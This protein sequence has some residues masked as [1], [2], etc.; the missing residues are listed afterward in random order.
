MLPELKVLL[1]IQALDQEII[2]LNQQLAKYPQIW[3]EVKTRLAQKRD[4]LDRA[5]KN[6]ERHVK[7][8]RRVEQ[9]LRLFSDDL[10]R[11]QT[12]Q[13][14]LRTARE[15]QAISTQ[16]EATR[17]KISQAEEQGLELI[18]KDEEIDRAV[19]EARE[20]LEKI[21]EVYKKEKGRIREQ[22]NEKKARVAD[23]EKERNG[24][25]KGVDEKV[26]AAYDQVTKRYP[27]EALV[28]VRSSSCTGCHWQL[29]PN[30]LVEVHTQ[31][32]ITFCTHC[33]RILTEDEQFQPQDSDAG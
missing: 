10:R 20:E 31:E 13:Q 32:K 9:K 11:Y 6:R 22:F 4:G 26:L 28:A 25:R 5:E 1:E 27:G 18:G 12:Q 3:E 29:L 24:L 30:Q 16:I 8:R 33:G 17:K 2:E 23:L 19:T 14:S 21:E 7:E 15:A